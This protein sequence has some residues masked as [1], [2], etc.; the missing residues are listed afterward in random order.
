MTRAVRTV[1]GGKVTW[2]VNDLNRGEFDQYI[3]SMRATDKNGETQLVEVDIVERRDTAREGCALAAG[4]V[5]GP[6]C[7]D[8]IPTLVENAR[9]SEAAE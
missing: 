9:P 6:E 1:S 4:T 7:Q 5:S 2:Y 8:E 3:R